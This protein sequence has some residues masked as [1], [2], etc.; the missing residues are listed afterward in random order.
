MAFLV[1]DRIA[2]RKIIETGY[3]NTTHLEI[4]SGLELGDTVVLTG[5]SGLKDG[6]KV[7]ILEPRENSGAM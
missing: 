5:V 2:H 3:V 7:E 1:K 6:S 4:L